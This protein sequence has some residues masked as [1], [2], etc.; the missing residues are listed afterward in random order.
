[1]AKKINALK[2][3]EKKVV[4]KFKVLER[5]AIRAGKSIKVKGTVTMGKYTF[6]K[7]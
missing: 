2:K 4:K 3:A 5:K 7:D 1:M 6:T